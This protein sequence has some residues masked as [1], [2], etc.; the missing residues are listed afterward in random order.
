[1][2]RL[3]FII[4]TFWAATALAK[5][6]VVLSWQDCLKEATRNNPQVAASGEV[7]RQ[8]K[9]Q[10]WVTE[11]PMLPQ[12]T[13]EFSANKSDS[14]S[15]GAERN[16][17]NYS[18]RGNQLIFDGLKTYKDVQAAKEDIRASEEDLTVISADVRLNLR[19]AFADLM[20]TQALVPIV[21]KIIERRKQNLEMIRLSYESGR[22]HEGALLLAEADL[23]SAQYDLKKAKRDMSAAQYALKKELGWYDDRPVKVKGEFKLAQKYQSQPDLQY[24]A[25]NHPQVKRNMA[26]K[27][28]AKYGLQSAKAEFSPEIDF[29]GEAGKI[30]TGITTSD[31]GWTV[32]VNVSLPVFEGGRRIANTRKAQARFSETAF[33]EKSEYD[34]VLSNLDAAWQNLQDAIEEVSVQG[35]Y[36]KADEVRAKIGRAQ[37]A[38]GLL[39]FDNWIIIENNYVNSQKA[40]VNAE[41]NMLLAEAQWIRAKGGDLNYE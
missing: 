36:L 23:A 11:S 7:I 33:N 29:S 34:A 13:S 2:R 1:M 6:E 18:V 24:L 21:Q 41:A 37:Y 30:G 27:D 8:N 26:R 10:R 31:N 12:V 32:G 22:E 35:K 4:L 38:N 17:Y 19:R 16:R 28:S 25:A 15:G 9:A 14:F 40:Y 3:I 20:R 5:G 39:I